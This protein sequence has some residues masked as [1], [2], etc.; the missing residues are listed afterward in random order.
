MEVVHGESLHLPE[1]ETMRYCDDVQ[2]MKSTIEVEMVGND[3]KP[4]ALR[5]FDK[6]SSK[7]KRQ[8][9]SIHNP[10]VRY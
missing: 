3:A 10:K 6:V 2:S 4:H 7:P 5:S 1:D 8:S 9:L